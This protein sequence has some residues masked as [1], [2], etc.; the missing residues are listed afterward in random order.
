[1]IPRIFHF[2]WIGDE[3]KRPD[4]YIDTWRRHN[5]DVAVKIWGNDELRERPWI[6]AAHMR[7]YATREL[8][9]VADLMRWE[10]LLDEGGIALDADSVCLQRLPDWLF[11]CEMFAAWENELA[12]PGLVATGAVGSMPGN[13]FIARLVEDLRNTPSLAGRMA[14]QATGPLCLTEAHRRHHYANLTL[15]PSHFFLPRHY[16]GTVYAGGGPVYADQCWDSTKLLLAAG[17]GT[18]GAAS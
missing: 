12:R 9:G 17:E 8:A 13:P 15:L 1:M 14:W 6:N 10:I 4:Q 16:A 3:S 18:P 2:V 5:P 7:D 11:E